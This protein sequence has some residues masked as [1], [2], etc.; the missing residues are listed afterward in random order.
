MMGSSTEPRGE[1]DHRTA[2][3]AEDDRSGWRT[4]DMYR[5]VFALPWP[6]LPEGMHCRG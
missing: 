3:G 1:D 5:E 4:E 6:T 2:A